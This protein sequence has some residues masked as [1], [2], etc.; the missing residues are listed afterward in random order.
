ML[1]R[2]TMAPVHRELSHIFRD[3]RN[4]FLVTVSLAFLLILLGGDLA[5]QVS[6]LAQ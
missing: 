3:P 6:R 2:C 5:L 1:M 4:L